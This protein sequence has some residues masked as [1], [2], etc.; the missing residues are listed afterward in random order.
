M[1]V[2]KY[3]SDKFVTVFIPTLNGGDTIQELLTSVLKQELPKGYSLEVLVTDSGSKDDTVDIIRSFKDRIT[4][5][6]IPSSEFGHGKTRQRAA[7]RAKGEFILF[8]SQ[9]A[10]PYSDRWLIHMIE[11]FY[12]SDRVGCVYG[13]Q[14]PRPFAPPTIK[15]EVATVFGGLGHPESISLNREKSLV[16]MK[17]EGPLNSFFSDVNSA[18]RKDLVSIIPFRDLRY[19]EDQALATD[20]QH[21]G[22]LKAYAPQGSVWHSNEYTA[23]EYYHRKFDEYVGLFNSVAHDMRPSYRSLL[24]G[25]VRPTL[26]DWSFTM[27]DGEYNKRAKIKF[28]LLSPA[29]N[30]FGQLG[31]FM[32]ARYHGNTDKIHKI[33]LEERRKRS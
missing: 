27:H 22:Y 12:I 31:K 6:E 3:S 18:V 32:A 14:I 19:A 10:T 29:Y 9:D 16:D 23:K 28:L 21:A 8:L 17:S 4:L 24:L 30:Y 7:E 11:P 2:L 25:W 26:H 33:S 15:R 5:D 20:M 13:R 1:A